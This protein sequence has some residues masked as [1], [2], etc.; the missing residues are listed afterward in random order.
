MWYPR[1]LFGPSVDLPYL[2]IMLTFECTPDFMVWRRH[3]VCAIGVVSSFNLS[4][5]NKLRSVAASD[6]YLYRLAVDWHLDCRLVKYNAV[7][8]VFEARHCGVTV[9][10]P[11]IRPLLK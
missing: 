5:I 2:E 7:V 4:L 9:T 10:R 3:C 1:L 11:W 8:T 6:D